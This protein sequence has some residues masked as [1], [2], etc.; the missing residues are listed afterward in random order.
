MSDT[1]VREVGR[2]EDG[3]GRIVIVGVSYDAVTLRTL[4][5]R[6][7]GAA[8]LGMAQQEELGQLLIAAVWQ[9]AWQRCRMDADTDRLAAGAA[10]AP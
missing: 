8:E 5:T 4:H 10:G 7:D 6:T 1:Y 3:Q 9:A 2:L